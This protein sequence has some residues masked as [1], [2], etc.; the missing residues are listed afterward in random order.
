MSSKNIMRKEHST[1]FYTIISVVT[2]LVFFGVWEMIPRLGIVPPSMLAAPSDVVLRFIDKLSNPNPD[3]A[4]LWVHVWVSLKEALIGYL[5]ALAIGI[6]VGL[7]M[8]WFKV[9][10]G[11]VR[12]VFEIIRPIPSPAWIPLC[13]IWLGIGL[14]SKVFI[15]QSIDRRM[16]I[17]EIADAKGVSVS[18][19]MTEIEGIVATGTKLDLDYYIYRNLDE[20][21]IDEIYNYFKE[22]AVSDSV[23]D[24]INAL[25]SDYEEMEIRL[26]RIK[27][28]CEIAN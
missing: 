28:I 2:L 22:E 21:V 4:V 16:S 13:I 14:A 8:G 5:L 1:T 18:D 26:V 15:I 12:P 27:F 24:A 7:A 17:E 6:P 23:D 25:G 20:Y 3:G 19:L 11:L 10:E 9:F